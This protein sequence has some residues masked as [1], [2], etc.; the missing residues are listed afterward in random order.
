MSWLARRMQVGNTRLT[1]ERNLLFGLREQEAL[2][3]LR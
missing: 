3:C 2:E 1:Y